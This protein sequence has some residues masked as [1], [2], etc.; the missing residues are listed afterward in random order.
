[1]PLSFGISIS[2][3]LLFSTPSCFPQTILPFFIPSSTSSLSP[4][5]FPF[6]LTLESYLLHAKLSHPSIIS[7]QASPSIHRIYLNP[8]YL[9]REFSFV[10]LNSSPF[11]LNYDYASLLTINLRR[12]CTEKN[13]HRSTRGTSSR[14]RVG[15]RKKREGGSDPPGY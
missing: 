3:A 13:F 14:D 9:S 5:Q 4:L 1:M 8:F 7:A 10:P 6:T 15:Y 2:P 12:V 11:C